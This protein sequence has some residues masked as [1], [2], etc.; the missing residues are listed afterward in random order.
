MK[1]KI[2]KCGVIFIILFSTIL[3]ISLSSL[4]ETLTAGKKA[5]GFYLTTLEGEKIYLSDLLK[6]QNVVLI[7]FFRTDC[8]PCIKEFPLL[9]DMQKDFKNKKVKMFL[10]DVEEKD[11]IVTKFI[12][13]KN[14]TIPVLL[15]TYK[16]I[17]TTY[18]SEQK[19]PQIFVIDKTGIVKYI[20][21]KGIDV[22]EAKDIESLIENLIKN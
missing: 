8:K 1:S 19:V 5:P 18:S 15:D 14:I 10:I 7:N 6:E 22:K 16:E 17:F 13:E 4:C 9:H 21:Q 20:H 11:E 2:R 3:L 12:K